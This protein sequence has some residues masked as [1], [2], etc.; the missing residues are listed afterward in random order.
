M[1]NE[2][3]AAILVRSLYW[4]LS[5][6]RGVSHSNDGLTLEAMGILNNYAAELET[7]SGDGGDRDA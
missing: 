4:V 7:A 2:A 1:T 3:I 6:M 5:G